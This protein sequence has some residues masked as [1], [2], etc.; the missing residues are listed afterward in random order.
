[1][2]LTGLQLVS[3]TENCP[4][5]PGPRQLHLSPNTA[6]P[7]GCAL[8]CLKTVEPPTPASPHPCSLATPNSPHSELLHCLLL[9]CGH[10]HTTICVLKTPLRASD[11]WLIF[12]GRAWLLTAKPS[13]LNTQHAWHLLCC[14]V[15]GS[16]YFCS[17]PPVPWGQLLTANFPSFNQWLFLLE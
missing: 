2:S 3:C 15:G 9:T 6:S 16:L 7:Q 5:M 17:K 14:A 10:L 1:M 8:W 12:Q 4:C 13:A 11:L